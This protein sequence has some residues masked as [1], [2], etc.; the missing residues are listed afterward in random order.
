MSESNI[1]VKIIQAVQNGEDEECEILTRA[2]VAEGIPPLII[3]EEGLSA[4]ISIV[5]E[6]FGNGEI[7]LPDLITAVEAMKEGLKVV[8]PELRK[9]K[10][11]S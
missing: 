7:F 11:Y 3:V 6:S 2:A 8:D 1:L 4:G 10:I 5:G 9:M